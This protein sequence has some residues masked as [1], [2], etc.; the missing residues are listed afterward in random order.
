MGIAGS[1]MVI[2]ISWWLAFFMMLP[3]GVRSQLE[4]GHVVPGTEPSAPTA[5]QLWRKAGWAFVIAMVIWAALFSVIEFELISI[6]DI[7]MPSGIRW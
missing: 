1:L 6:H 4:D 7:P 5:P 3:I 2:S